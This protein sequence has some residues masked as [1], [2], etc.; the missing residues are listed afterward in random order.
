MSAGATV[1]NQQADLHEL[2]SFVVNCAELRD[3]EKLLGTFNLFRVLRFEHGEIR[4]S[5]VSVVVVQTGWI[6]RAQGSVSSALADGG[7]FTRCRRGR[8]RAISTRWRSTLARS[9]Q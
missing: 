8:A 6:A 5:N 7:F 4:H 1:S 2:N 3:L 9:V